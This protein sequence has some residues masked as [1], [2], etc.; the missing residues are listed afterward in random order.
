MAKML[1]KMEYVKVQK[2]FFLHSIFVFRIVQIFKRNCKEEEKILN[3]PENDTKWR[4]NLGYTCISLIPECLSSK[5]VSIL[6]RPLASGVLLPHFTD[7]MVGQRGTV[8]HC[9]QT[10]P[11][12]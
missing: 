6:K 12:T 11:L 1:G 2:S 9:S 7:G 3:Y 5:N 8:F 10:L 4:P